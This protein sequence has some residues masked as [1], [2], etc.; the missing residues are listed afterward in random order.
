M[1]SSG[2]EGEVS[3]GEP[4]VVGAAV[5]GALAESGVG[6][7]SLDGVVL[8]SREGVDLPGAIGRAVEERGEAVVVCGRGEIV[9]WS[10]GVRWRGCDEALSTAL[11]RALGAR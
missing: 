6:E 3:G 4:G 2:G 1:S 10:G 8:R 7:V 11:R 5:A 9:V